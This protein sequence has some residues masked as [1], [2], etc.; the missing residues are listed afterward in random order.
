MTWEGLFLGYGPLGLCCVLSLV[1][2][3]LYMKV[4]DLQ[5]LRVNEN[6]E[7][8]RELVKAVEAQGH[9]RRPPAPSSKPP[10]LKTHFSTSTTKN[11]TRDS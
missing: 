11:R 7:R 6:R 5:E 3:H 10:P 4:S 9:S 1:V 2:R 8:Y